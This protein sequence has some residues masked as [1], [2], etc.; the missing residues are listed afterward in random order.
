MRVETNIS[1]RVWY[2]GKAVLR[3]KSRAGEL[4]QQ[5]RMHLEL[6]EDP[7][8]SPNIYMQAHNHPL[9]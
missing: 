5:L 1:E 3:G 4:S 7:D 9:T 2:V 6:V 8:S